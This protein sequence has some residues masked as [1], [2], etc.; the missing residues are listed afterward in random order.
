MCPFC[1]RP[2]NSE[3]RWN[4]ALQACPTC[5]GVWFTPTN[6]DT[7]LRVVAGRPGITP[8]PAS[9][10]PS[11]APSRACPDCLSDT[12]VSG[13]VRGAAIWRC[14]TCSGVFITEEVLTQLR[15]PFLNQNETDLK[16]T[17]GILEILFYLIP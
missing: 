11:G 6:A 2:L 9:F 10:Q 8:Q 7:Y 12:L 5:A 4:V 14:G 16:A 1:K 13:S 3:V 17:T 15:A